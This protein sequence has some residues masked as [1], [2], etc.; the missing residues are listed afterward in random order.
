MSEKNNYI[1]DYN[2]AK[3]ALEQGEFQIYLQP[4]VDMITSKL[5]GAEAL[6]RWIHPTLGLRM[7]MSYIPQFEETGLICDLDMYVFEEVCRIKAIWKKNDEIYSDVVISSNM[8]RLHLSD[9]LF[10][11]KLAE[12]A[13]K[14]SIPHNELEIEI[15][16]NTFVSDIDKMIVAIEEIKKQG[17]FISIDD[18]GSGFSGLNLL[19]DISVDTIKIDKSFLHGSGNTKRGQTLIRD[20]IALCLNLKADVITEGIETI[21]QV[22]FIKNCGCTVAQG[23]YYSKPLPLPEYEAFAKKYVVAALTN[24]SFRFEETLCSADGSMEACMIGD[25]VT[26]DNGMF[27]DTK[28]LYF[29]GGPTACNVVSIPKETLPT[30]SYTVSIWIKPTV[31]VQWA[32]VF[33]IRQNTGFVS[34]A[35][36]V[37]DEMSIFR[38]WN[39]SGMDGWNDIYYSKIPE[40]VWTHMALSYNAKENTLDAYVNGELIGHLDDVPT[41]RYVEEILIG[42]DNFKE[43]YI[44]FVDEVMIYNEPKNSTF[45]KELYNSYIQEDNYGKL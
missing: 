17:F 36:Y 16:E 35:P 31:S 12:V 40:N 45:I 21:E 15:T 11:S 39:S 7:P 1:F 22:N 23:F 41:S 2:E 13:D 34:I 43:S 4:K 30:D 20:I 37:G 28:A 32:S 18:F 8:S 14:Y 38:L 44:G 6:S 29:P 10:S 25:D 42:G 27:P 5:R 3:L 19:K 26:Y 9:P 24:Y 33:Y